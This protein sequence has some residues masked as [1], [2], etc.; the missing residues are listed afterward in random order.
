MEGLC[1]VE[2][3][4]LGPAQLH[5]VAPVAPPVNDNVEPAQIGFGEADAVTP[6]GTV[7]TV[8]DAV[9]TAAAEPQALLAVK[10]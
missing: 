1:K 2:V 5:A 7:L 3:K 4:L 8:T 10:E 6:V 9:F